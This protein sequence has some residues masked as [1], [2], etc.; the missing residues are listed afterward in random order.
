MEYFLT[1]MAEISPTSL[2]RYLSC[3]FTGTPVLAFRVES[4]LGLAVS[5]FIPL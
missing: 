1:D 2:S 4:N 5:H 3:A